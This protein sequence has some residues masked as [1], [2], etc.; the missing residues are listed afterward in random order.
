LRR[1]WTFSES[2]TFGAVLAAQT[3]YI[4]T[5]RKLY[6]RLMRSGWECDI[7]ERKSNHYW[8]RRSIGMSDVP[9]QM[10]IAAFNEE[11]GADEALQALKEAKWAGLI[12]IDNAAVIR[13]DE[14]NKLHIKE[15][16]DWGGGKGAAAGGAIGAAAGI[17]LGPGALVTGAVGALIGGLAAKLRDSGFSDARLKKVGEGLKPGTSAIIAVIEHKWVAELEREMAEA[18]ADVFTEQISADIAAQLDAG[19]EVAYTALSTTDAFAAGRVAVGEDEVEVGGLIITDDG[20][21]AGDMIATEEGAAAERLV[22]TDE[23]AVYEVGVAVPEEEA[24]GDEA[25]EEEIQ[26]A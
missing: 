23:G 1:K 12:G 19:R 17:L 18:G 24:A 7:L 4:C 15:T 11:K 10:L 13:R 3:L 9:V 6:N 26:E 5:G 16:G 14:K 2:G 21:I 22:V 20:L 25:T 8:C